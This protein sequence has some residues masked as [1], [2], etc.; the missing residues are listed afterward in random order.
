VRLG[1]S[2]DPETGKRN[3]G[4]IE[5]EHLAPGASPQYRP[6]DQLGK[7]SGTPLWHT[8]S[9]FRERPAI[10]SLFYCKQVGRAKR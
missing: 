9:C 1:N 7:F 10:G 3:G 4:F 5:S 6:N 2:I 8:D